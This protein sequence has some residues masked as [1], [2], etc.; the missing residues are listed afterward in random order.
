MIAVGRLKPGVSL[1]AAQAEATAISRQ[2]L[3]ARGEKAGGDGAQVVSLHEAF[4][5]GRDATR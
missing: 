3:E 1:A 4:F 2:V 5:G